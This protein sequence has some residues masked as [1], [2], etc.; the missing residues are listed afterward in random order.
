MMLGQNYCGRWKGSGN[1]E[2]KK[3]EKKKKKILE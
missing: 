3:K 2:R 1:F